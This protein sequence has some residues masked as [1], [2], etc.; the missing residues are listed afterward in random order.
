MRGQAPDNRTCAN[1]PDGP[2]WPW[3]DVAAP[4]SER[5][6]QPD[7]LPGGLASP[8]PA[9]GDKASRLRIV[10]SSPHPTPPPGTNDGDGGMTTPSLRRARASRRAKRAIVR[11]PPWR[12]APRHLPLRE[13]VEDEA[14]ADFAVAVGKPPALWSTSR[15]GRT[16]LRDVPRLDNFSVASARRSGRAR[17]RA[18]HFTSHVRYS[19]RYATA[20]PWDR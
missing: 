14:C 9:Y 13:E 16:Y 15:G 5:L 11:P 10:R 1:T 7:T 12:Y 2:A 18:F 4:R 20:H 19:V 3:R 8:A 17:R 6:Q